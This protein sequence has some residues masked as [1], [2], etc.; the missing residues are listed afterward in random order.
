MVLWVDMTYSSQRFIYQRPDVQLLMLFWEP[1][2]ALM[3]QDQ[4]RRAKPM[5][6]YELVT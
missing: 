3:T 6:D 2:E 1:L 5:V 4:A